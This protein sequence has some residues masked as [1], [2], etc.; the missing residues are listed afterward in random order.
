M[1]E[2]QSPVL[3]AA[4]TAEDKELIK[5]VLAKLYPL[6]EEGK[7]PNEIIAKLGALVGYPAPEGAYPAPSQYPGPQCPP[8]PQ[9][10]GLEQFLAGLPNREEVE[11]VITKAIEEVEKNLEEVRKKDLEALEKA[12]AEIAELRKALEAERAARE[13]TQVSAELKA[14][15]PTI[16]QAQPELID[17]AVSL[18]KSQDYEKFLA[19]LERIETLLSKATLFKEI[20][21]KAPEVKS[22]AEILEE[23]ARELVSKGLARTMEQ[24]RVKV[25]Q[26]DPELYRKL[27]GGE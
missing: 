1:A 10:R 23:K 18:R 14:K 27:R 25:L 6:F 20:G 16:A 19:N 22:E 13:A 5:G 26:A 21:E 4:L 8:Y 3:E 17:L 2:K 11:T 12:Q 9:A 7:I 24:A 15:F